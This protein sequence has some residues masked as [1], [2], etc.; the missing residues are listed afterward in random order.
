VG[1]PAQNAPDTID[2]HEATLS[3]EDGLERRVNNTL[4]FP[5]FGVGAAG[6]APIPFTYGGERVPDVVGNVR[7]TGT[8]GG[9]QAHCTRSAT[10]RRGS[11]PSMAR[12]CRSSTRSPACRTRL[13]GQEYGFAAVF[14]AY[15]NLLLRTHEEQ[16]VLGA[17]HMA[18]QARNRSPPIYWD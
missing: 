18:V 6:F 14:D 12:S 7:C 17:E 15:V 9:A 1:Q 8:W 13:C 4:V 2:W 10:W 3:L 5:L 11:P 16:G